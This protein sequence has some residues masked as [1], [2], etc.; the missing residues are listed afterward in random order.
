MALSMPLP[1]CSGCGTQDLDWIGTEGDGYTECCNEPITYEP[2][3][4][5]R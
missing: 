2:A 3:K 4:A 1:T 5:A